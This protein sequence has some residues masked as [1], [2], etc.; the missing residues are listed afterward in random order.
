MWDVLSQDYDRSIN[1]EKCLSNVESNIKP[2]SI[3]V[4]HDSLKASENLYY[5][6]PVLLEKFTGEYRFL[7]IIHAG[8]PARTPNTQPVEEPRLAY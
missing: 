4:F 2:G 1:P 7:P 5:A 8:S 3:V 6:L